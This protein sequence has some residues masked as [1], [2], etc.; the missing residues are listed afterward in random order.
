MTTPI[1]PADNHYLKLEGTSELLEDGTLQGTVI[2]VAE[3]QTDA[4]IRRAFTRSYQSSWK[5]YLPR[6]LYS[7]A[8][9]AEIAVQEFNDPIDLSKPMRLKMQ[10]KIPD[11]AAFAGGRMIFVPFLAKNPFNDGVTGAEMSM[12]TSIAERKYLFRT[13]CSKTVEIS[14]TI[15]IPASYT[16]ANLPAFTPSKDASSSFDAAYTLKGN[17]VMLVAG[18]RME[19][20]V[21]EP[22]DWPVFRS[23]LKE[24]HKLSETAIVLE[25]KEASR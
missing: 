17:T 22:G 5:E 15:T 14:E 19:K 13:R 3:G 18:H 4:A 6:I 24:R 10:Y 16:A 9:Q 7:I 8:P 2:A 20:R 12:D 11:Y 1:S 25:K 23:G 21:Y